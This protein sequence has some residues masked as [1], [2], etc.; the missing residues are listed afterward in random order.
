MK[1]FFAICIFLTLAQCNSKKPLSI[2]L[3]IGQSNMAGRAAIQP[4]D[5]TTLSHVFLLNDSD[6][7]EPA[8]NPLNRYSTVR[9]SLDMQKLGP[10]W[11]F[12]KTLAEHFPQERFGLIVNAHG[13]SSIDEWAK[14]TY[15]YDEAIIRAL[16]AQKTGNL[17]GIIWHQGESDRNH[18]GAYA[19]K[20]K[21]MI[22]NL[23]K[24]LGEPNL[25]VVVGEVG[26]WRGN[27]DSINNV[28]DGLKDEINNLGVARADGLQHRG[29]SLH[30]NTQSQHVLGERYAKAM[31]Q[32]MDDGEGVKR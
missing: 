6:A 25:P 22:T 12:A 5:T 31:M 30:F 21:T 11:G 18:A 23:R 8:K 15:Y 26:N 20:F 16:K 28:L 19:A 4:E 7:W 17:V 3:C 1:Y 13:G 10:S 24:D 14:G 32:L 27:S 2:F 29:D 9:K